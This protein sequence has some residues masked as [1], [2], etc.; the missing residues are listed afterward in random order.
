MSLFLCSPFTNSARMPPPGPFWRF[1]EIASPSNVRFAPEAA[2][3]YPS[4]LAIGHRR[5]LSS[6]R[7]SRLFPGD[8]RFR[9]FA[10]FHRNLRQTIDKPPAHCRRQ[11]A[12][13]RFTRW[14]SSTAW[15]LRPAT[16]LFVLTGFALNSTG[17]FWFDPRVRWSAKSLLIERH[18]TRA[19][20]DL[21]IFKLQRLAAR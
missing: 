21:D 4:L 2:I 11:S 14:H 12:E 16:A 15:A 6:R 10:R 8:R 1:A 5:P 19:R 17:T 7:P 20:N 9:H 13:W 3:L 18:G